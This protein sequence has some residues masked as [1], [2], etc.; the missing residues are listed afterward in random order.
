MTSVTD[1]LAPFETERVKGNS[2]EWF[3]GEFLEI[4]TLRD[5][6]FKKCKRS[7]LNLDKEI[8][9]KTRKKTHRLILRERKKK[10]KRERESNSKTN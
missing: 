6:S 8:Y 5:N 3:Y 9:N 2:Q 1:K 10:K 7:K 4:I